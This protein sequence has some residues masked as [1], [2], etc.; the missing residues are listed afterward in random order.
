MDEFS[1]QVAGRLEKIEQMLTRLV[2][3]RSAKEFYTTTEVAELLGKAEYTVRE[4]CRLKRVRAQ[5][6]PDGRS[7]LIPGAE[8]LRIRNSGNRPAEH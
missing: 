3:Q 7:W 6:A 1:E 8:L 2:E 4:W 5:K